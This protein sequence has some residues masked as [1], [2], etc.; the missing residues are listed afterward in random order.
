MPNV[1]TSVLIN[2]PLD[3]VYEVAKDNRSFPDFMSDV[4]SL[5]VLE[6]NGDRVVS[7]WVGIVPTFGLKIRWK[8]V[9]IWDDVAHT[10]KFDQLEGDYDLM[11]GIWQFS[12]E[13]GVT[14]FDSSLD[15]EYKVPGL[16]A[17]VNKVIH[18]IV[19]KNM[20]SVLGAIKDRAES[21]V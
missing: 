3:K 9:D 20:Q 11:T 1:V 18:N 8:Q 16:G 15:Y 6:E 13:N 12:E 17:L 14:K 19:V 10:C 2:A 4:K 21:K 7:E 5:E